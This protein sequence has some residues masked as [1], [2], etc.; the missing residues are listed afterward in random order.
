MVYDNRVGMSDAEAQR[1]FEMFARGDDVGRIPEGMGIGLY[2]VKRIAQ[3]LNAQTRLVSR[4]NVGTA[5]GVS[6]A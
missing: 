4:L 6:L 2:S 3:Q 5:I 1:C